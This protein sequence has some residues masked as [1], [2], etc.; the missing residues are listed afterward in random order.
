MNLDRVVTGRKFFKTSGAGASAGELSA[1]VFLI[2]AAA[3][4]KEEWLLGIGQTAVA[5]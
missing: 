5:V 2:A 4:A 3:K 1:S